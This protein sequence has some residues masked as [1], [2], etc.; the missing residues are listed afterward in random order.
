MASYAIVSI[1]G[2]DLQENGVDCKCHIVDGGNLRPER[3]G[4]TR[5]PANPEAPSFTQTH[6]SAKGKKFGILG[7]YLPTD[8]IDQLVDAINAASAT[9]DGNFNVTSTD[10]R[11]TFN[12]LCKPDYSQESWITYPDEV[13]TDERSNKN[14]LFRFVTD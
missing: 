1:A 9:G 2:V 7:L 10:E 13:R 12:D 6:L 14:T 4:I 11:Q 5:Y 8:L 3:V